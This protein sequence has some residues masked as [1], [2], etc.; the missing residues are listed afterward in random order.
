MLLYVFPSFAAANQADRRM[1]NPV[2]RSNYSKRATIRPNAHNVIWGNL[3]ELPPLC[4]HI[5]RVNGICSKVQMIW[6]DALRVIARVKNK[7][8]L[9]DGSNKR[10][11]CNPVRFLHY[12]IDFYPSITVMT[13]CPDPIPA[14][15]TGVLDAPIAQ[16]FFDR[17]PGHFHRPVLA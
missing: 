10:L 8:P 11:K 1:V 4:N 5:G 13:F 3:F 9:A 17:W 14:P 16:A 7:K 15:S 2:I 6:I 12:V